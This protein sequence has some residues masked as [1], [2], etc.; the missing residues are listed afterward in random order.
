MRSPPF[1]QGLTFRTGLGLFPYLC[2]WQVA[3]FWGWSFL[4]RKVNLNLILPL[5]E[6]AADGN[7]VE[8]ET[9]CGKTKVECG[10]RRGS[11]DW[12]PVFLTGVDT[13]DL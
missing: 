10:H 6:L 3:C 1:G 4:G 12:A 9:P 7:E 13:E 2:S 5:I 11:E 8:G